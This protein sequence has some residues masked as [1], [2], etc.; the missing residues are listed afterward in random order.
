[1]IFSLWTKLCTTNISFYFSL[2][3]YF[4]TTILLHSSFCDQH[5][6]FQVSLTKMWSKNYAY[7]K[8]G[9]LFSTPGEIVVVIIIKLNVIKGHCSKWVF[10]CVSNGF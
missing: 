2:K 3:I 6:T 8:Y 1:M 5:N 10:V 4:S 9:I 7:Y